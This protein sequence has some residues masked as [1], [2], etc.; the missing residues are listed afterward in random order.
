MVL[1]SARGWDYLFRCLRS[2]L[3]SQGSGMYLYSAYLPRRG[4][5]GSRW[6]V[7]SVGVVSIL[8]LTCVLYSLALY[9]QATLSGRMG[10]DFLSI[11]KCKERSEGVGFEYVSKLLL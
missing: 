8:L 9:V 6:V 5:A 1:G 4:Q 10:F 11:G 3:C 7:L 2:R